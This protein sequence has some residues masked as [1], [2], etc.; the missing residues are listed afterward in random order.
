[1]RKVDITVNLVVLAKCDKITQKGSRVPDGY[2]IVQYK[3]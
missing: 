2:L 1:M 3:V